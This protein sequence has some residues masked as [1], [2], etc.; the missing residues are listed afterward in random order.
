[1]MIV[2]EAISAAGSPD[3]QAIWLKTGKVNIYLH[4]CIPEKKTCGCAAVDRKKDPLTI[5][6]MD[7][8]LGRIRDLPSL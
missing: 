6:E 1:M 3:V 8:G 7:S 2:P 5:K 4:C